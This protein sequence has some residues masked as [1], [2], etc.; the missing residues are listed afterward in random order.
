MEL[1]CSDIILFWL[2]IQ[3]TVQGSER[4]SCFSAVLSARPYA[5]H[6]RTICL[7]EQGAG[8]ARDCIPG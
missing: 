4:G 7:T 6:A 1:D 8:N 2:M 5:L 3:Y